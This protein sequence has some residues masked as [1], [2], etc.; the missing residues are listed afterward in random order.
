M[1][2]NLRL[3]GTCPPCK[4]CS[5]RWV[6][7]DGANCHSTCPTYLAY[8]ERSDRCKET[9]G[10]AKKDGTNCCSICTMYLAYKEK[11]GG[12]EEMPASAA[13]DEYVYLKFCINASK[14]Q[15]S[16]NAIKCKER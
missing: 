6:S 13:S 5:E 10:K 15:R 16:Y 3:N 12:R 14:W 8:K 7:E 9:R 11:Y 2:K 1:R 4:D